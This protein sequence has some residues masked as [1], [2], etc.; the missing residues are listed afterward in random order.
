MIEAIDSLIT[1]CHKHQ[2]GWQVGYL[3]DD[4]DELSGDGATVAVVHGPRFHV[5]IFRG[6]STIL[7][8]DEDAYAAIT[9]AL[10]TA[11]GR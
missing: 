7:A 9:R 4:P 8:D 3:A 6:D 1:T 2:W 10:H 11:L 5:A